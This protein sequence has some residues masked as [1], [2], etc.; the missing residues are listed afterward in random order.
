MHR[1]DWNELPDGVRAA[2]RELCG[3][4][5][6][7]DASTVGRNSAFAANL[8]VANGDRVFCKGVL[9]GT[10]VTR[11]H[12]REAH[13]NGSMPSTRAPRLL[14]D[15]EVDG[16]LLLGLEHIAGRH[17]DLTPGS[18]DLPVITESLSTLVRD[19]T[20]TPT[21]RVP[22]LSAKW[23]RVRPWRSLRDD[24]PAALD[25]WTHAHLAQFA[26]EEPVAAEFVAG[27]TLAH[28]DVHEHNMLVR[29]AS[30]Y[31]V[32]WA[33]AHVAAAWVDAAYLVIRLI[34]AGHS[35]ASAERWAATTPSWLAAPSAA[36]DAFAVETYGMWEYLR[37]IDPRPIREAPT[38]AAR[39]WAQYRRSER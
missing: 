23:N 34:Q 22:D 1:H 10:D 28:T 27:N 20:P 6:H 4:I 25:A 38:R 11:M 39:Q 35:P 36:V 3:E 17:A 15:V 14:W 16:W 26:A 21:P 5:V 8:R 32:D 30:A 2:V 9:I 29:D 31:L 19:L 33:W 37:H 7:V 18:P 24:R 12:R 13:V